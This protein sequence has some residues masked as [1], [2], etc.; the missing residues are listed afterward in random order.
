MRYEGVSGHRHR[1]GLT[2]TG[3]CCW[4][5]KGFCC[6]LKERIYS[7]NQSWDQSIPEGRITS[8]QNAWIKSLRNRI[9]SCQ[10]LTHGACSRGTNERAFLKPHYLISPE[11]FKVILKT[12]FLLLPCNCLI[13]SQK[14]M[15]Q[16]SEA[17]VTLT[18][19]EG[20]SRTLIKHRG[21]LVIAQCPI[22]V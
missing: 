15:E 2:C 8:I 11:N 16:I 20:L 6:V 17:S 22:T 14:E 1:M 19:E 9:L 4:G 7:M 18:L 10:Q 5:F 12:K 3:Q 13:P 21:L